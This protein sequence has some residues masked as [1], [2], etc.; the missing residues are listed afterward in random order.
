MDKIYRSTTGH[1]LVKYQ[2]VAFF[3]VLFLS[4]IY[5]LD[6]PNKG[7]SIFVLSL[8]FATAHG[9]I[10][11]NFNKNKFKPYVCII[12]ILFGKWQP[13]PIYNRITI[14]RTRNKIKM[15]SR[16]SHSHDHVALSY[17]VRLYDNDSHDYREVSRGNLRKVKGAATTLSHF[18]SIDF[19]DFTLDK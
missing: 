2:R 6:N 12:G 11:I 17:S 14:V 8:A 13:M 5:L 18:T 15:Y 19:E 16:T 3:V 7:I 9:G 4:P 10:L 1:F